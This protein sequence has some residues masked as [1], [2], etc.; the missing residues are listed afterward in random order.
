MAI[1]NGYRGNKNTKDDVAAIVDT[2]DSTIMAKDEKIPPG[3]E[4][5]PPVE[6]KENPIVTKTK[7]RV[8]RKGELIEKTK[9]SNTESGRKG[10][11]KKV[12]SPTNVEYD[13]DALAGLSFLTTGSNSETI[14]PTPPV[15]HRIPVK[16]PLGGLLHPVWR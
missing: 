12:T 4:K 14:T 3:E 5:V 6:E 8:N 9:W 2:Y 11:S 13:A 7:T 10:G 16:R 1:L 15:V